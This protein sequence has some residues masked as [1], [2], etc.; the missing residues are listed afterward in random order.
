[1][2][3]GDVVSLQQAIAHAGKSDRTLR[4]WCHKYGIGRQTSPGAP[5]EISIIALE[6]VLHGDFDALEQLR[7][8]Q[9]TSLPVRRYFEHLGVPV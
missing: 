6:M 8:G 1:M 5:L 7:A 3:S 4:G 9:R 2:R